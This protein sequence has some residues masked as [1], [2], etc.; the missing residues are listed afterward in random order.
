MK[1]ILVADRKAQYRYLANYAKNCTRKTA[2]LFRDNDSALPIIDLLDRQG[3]PYRC[4]QVD[5]TFFTSR[6]VRDITDF[7]HFASDPS[8]GELFMRLYYKFNAG[9]SKA[10]AETAVRLAAARCS[11]VPQELLSLDLSRWSL[12]KVKAL[13][14]HFNRLTDRPAEQAVYCIVNYMGYGDYLDQHKADRR[15]IPILEAIAAQVPTLAQLLERL[16]ELR[17]LVKSGANDPKAL[18]IL[19]TIHSSKDWNTTA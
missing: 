5:S 12:Q 9:V 8:N 16:G 13:Q 3:T 1:Q 18:T 17:E 14:S 11:T 6:I 4:R 7:I 10:Q 2:V 19:S 15:K